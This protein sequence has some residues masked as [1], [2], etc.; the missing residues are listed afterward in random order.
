MYL[1][2]YGLIEKP[3][4]I[5]TDPKFLWLGEKHKEALATLKYGVL[6]RRGFL[7]L[8]GD[9]GTG[10]TT[11]IKTLIKELSEDVVVATVVD[12]GLERDEFFSLL[13]QTFAIK[14]RFSNKLEFLN[15]FR[16]FL[17]ETH[18][19]GKTVLLIIDEAQNLSRELLEEVRLLSNIELEDTKLLNIFFVGQNEFNDILIHCSAL[20]QRITIMHHLRTLTEAET[21]EYI[22][23]RLEVAGAQKKIFEKKSI[24]KI[25]SASGGYPR[26]INIICDHA[27]LTGFVR[28]TKTIGPSIIRE[29]QAELRL[30]GEAKTALPQTSLSHPSYPKKKSLL[31]PVLYAILAILVISST[32]LLFYQDRYQPYIEKAGTYYRQLISSD[33]DPP[34]RKPVA[35]VATAVPDSPADQ[36][37]NAAEP[38]EAKKLQDAAPSTALETPGERN[39]NSP[40]SK[41]APENPSPTPTVSNSN[42]PETTKDDTIPAASPLPSIDENFKIIVPFDFNTN[43]ISPDAHG[44]LDGLA[45][46]MAGDSNIKVVIKGYTDTLGNHHYN[47]KLSEFRALVVKSYLV[48]KGVAPERIKTVGMAEKNPVATNDTV[49]GRAANRR[50]EIESWAD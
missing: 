42:P 36:P 12:P 39:H 37:G 33:R 3:F 32:Y 45:S 24:R 1:S 9:V 18:A 31:W 27:L 26:L 35:T 2:H 23:Y 50:V 5:T 7:L 38:D 48:G 29:C 25:F 10:K 6:D 15:R 40:S 44:S 47:V 28:E 41:V 43:E 34:V 4:Q 20:R 19:R 22:T 8:T 17:T 46:A 14:G 49:S 13:S 11:L 30:Q 21:A 16:D